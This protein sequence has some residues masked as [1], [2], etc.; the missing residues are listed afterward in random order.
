MQFLF[1]AVDKQAPS[2]KITGFNVSSFLKTF[3]CA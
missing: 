3:N 1:N 2:L